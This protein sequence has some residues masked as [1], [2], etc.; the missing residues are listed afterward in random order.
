MMSDG[1]QHLVNKILITTHSFTIPDKV[2]GPTH[3]GLRSFCAAAGFSRI[4]PQR[5][6][7][8][9]L[10]PQQPQLSDEDVLI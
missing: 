6:H 2:G 8:E 1:H 3:R 9:L 4:Q 10:Q 5:Q 7:T